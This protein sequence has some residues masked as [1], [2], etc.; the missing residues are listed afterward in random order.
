MN[1]ALI[2]RPLTDT[3]INATVALYQACF[4]EPPWFE[5]F[6]FDEVAAEFREILSWPDAA[7]LVAV[8]DEKIVGGTVGFDLA[9]K[10]DV[11][12]LV[13]TVFKPCFYF[14]E[15]FVDAAMRRNGIAGALIRERSAHARRHNYTFGAVRTSINQT[16]IRT[17]YQKLGYHTV[18]TQEVT[19]T[20]IIDGQATTANDL[21]V[22]IAGSIP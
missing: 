5:T 2:V 21:R 18:A 6:E 22:I 20:K 14:S 8:L 17:I 10:P 3:D 11:N 19:S 15:L 7:F 12:V 1:P 16:I 4:A 9:R 13:P